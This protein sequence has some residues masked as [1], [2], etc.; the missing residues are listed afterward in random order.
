MNFKQWFESE[1]WNA[2]YQNIE[3]KLL[4]SPI[5][6]KELNDL[7]MV[8]FSTVHSVLG[9]PEGDANFFVREFNK[10]HQNQQQQ[11]AHNQ[12]QDAAWMKERQ[13]EFYY[14]VLPSNRLK[15]VIKNG[16]LPNQQAV[17]TNYTNHSKGRIFLCEKE[18][19]NFWKG[20]IEQHLFHNGQKEKLAVIRIRK[21]L[22]KVEPD[23]VGTQDSKTPSYYAATP[24]P[25]Q[26]IEVV[27]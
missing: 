8:R 19:I 23:P 12:Q 6:Q 2:K 5:I 18:G 16:L 26:N 24:V 22:V 17:F 4:N 10:R 13:D 25:P 11:L 3:P 14:H 9:L 1:D 7:G 21:D 15:S 20:Q 27:K